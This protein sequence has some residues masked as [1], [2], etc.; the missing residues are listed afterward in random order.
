M[1]S[2][3]E[4]ESL[5]NFWVLPSSA[6]IGKKSLD[7]GVCFWGLVAL[8]SK[9][10]SSMIS[11]SSL[12]MVRKVFFLFSN[13]LEVQMKWKKSKPFH[14]HRPS[15]IYTS[16]DNRTDLIFHNLRLFSLVS[17]VPSTS[18]FNLVRSLNLFLKV[19]HYLALRCHSLNT[20]LVLCSHT[21]G[22]K[23]CAERGEIDKEV[24]TIPISPKLKRLLNSWTNRKYRFLTSFR[25]RGIP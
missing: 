7:T 25:K 21:F 1:L 2:F 16:S 19:S 8:L 18:P 20:F 13:L 23:E 9:S 15:N 22:G 4:T 3:L 24:L 11:N 6:Q 10:T 17:S 14:S 5:L 12:T